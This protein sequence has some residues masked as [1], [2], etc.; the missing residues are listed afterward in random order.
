M[1]AMSQPVHDSERGRLARV[2]IQLF[3]GVRMPKT[4]PSQVSEKTHVL[5][6]LIDGSQ[7][8]SKRLVPVTVVVSASHVEVAVLNARGD[9]VALARVEYWND[10][11]VAH[12][13]DA[14][15][16]S[17]DAEPQTIHLIDAARVKTKGKRQ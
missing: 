7:P 2:S 6:A 14:A 15:T 17:A 4:T 3:L 11:I 8:A 5:R 12:L 13:W 9:E 10:E 1:R 16:V